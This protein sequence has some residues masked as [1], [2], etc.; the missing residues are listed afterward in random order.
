MVLNTSVRILRQSPL[1]KALDHVS[2][3]CFQ[4]QVACTGRVVGATHE[5]HA[6]LRLKIVVRSASERILGSELGL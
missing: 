6:V 4:G 1:P 5:L 2:N 3:A